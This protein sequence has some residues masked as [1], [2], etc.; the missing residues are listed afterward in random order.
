MP[1]CGP[2]ADPLKIWIRRIDPTE[3]PSRIRAGVAWAEPVTYG[4]G[5]ISRVQRWEV[6]TNDRTPGLVSESWSHRGKGRWVR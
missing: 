5:L 4:K 2:G 1:V 6:Y 3:L